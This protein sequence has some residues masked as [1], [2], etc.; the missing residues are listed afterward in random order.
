MANENPG[1][2]AA[3][4]AQ[5]RKQL[6][7]LRERL[8]GM[9]QAREAEL[10]ALTEQYGDEPRDSG[11]EGANMAQI[12][13]DHALHHAGDRRLATVERALEKIREGTY[14]LSD[15][16]GEPIPRVRLEAVPD[17]IY[18]VEEEERREYERRSVR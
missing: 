1:L 18:T 7:E 16:S 12:D 3:F 17:A 4:V 9:E 2:S 6:E 10:R 15:A 13:I 8:L 14:G 5:Q 11:D